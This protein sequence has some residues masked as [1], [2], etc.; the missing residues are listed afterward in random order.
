V[1][2]VRAGVGFEDGV[3][4]EPQKKRTKAVA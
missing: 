3:R 4:M 2:L 1:P